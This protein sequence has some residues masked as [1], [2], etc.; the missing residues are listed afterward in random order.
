MDRKVLHFT[1]GPVQGF[2]ND[3]RRL[4]DYWAGSFLLSLLA[5]HAM[6]AVTEA[7]GT[8]VFP[9]V[10]DDPLFLAL[11][12]E[13][14]A[15]YI[16]SLPNRFKA[17]VPAERASLI[18]RECAGSV[19]KAWTEIYDAIWGSYFENAAK[20]SAHHGT[21]A[22]RIWQRQTRNFWTTAWVV[23][24]EPTDGSDGAWLDLRKNWRTHFPACVEDGD[25]CRLMGQY[26]ELSGF[27][28]IGEKRQQQVFWES[29]RAQLSDLSLDISPA[30]PL[31]A[32]N[33]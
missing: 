24:D 14:K 33:S 6:R 22:L 11:T 23:G 30:E 29:V 19:S 25:H 20:D 2:I 5:G 31:C 10:V 12:G 1:I 7:G 26:Q 27:H 32:T 17:E 28:R 16:G 15:P 9:N 3:A 18:A 4:R 21:A 8:V 13:E